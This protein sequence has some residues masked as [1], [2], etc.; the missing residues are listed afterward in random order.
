MEVETLG[1]ARSLGW[2]LHMRC[3]GGY[4]EETKV[5]AALRLSQAAR[6]GDAGC[7][8]RPQLSDLKASGGGRRLCAGGPTQRAGGFPRDRM[9]GVGP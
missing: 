6:Y 8:A 4:R 3:A 1:V 5:H 9:T 2:K 7:H